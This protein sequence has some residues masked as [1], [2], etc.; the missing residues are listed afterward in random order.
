MQLA[1]VPALYLVQVRIDLEMIFA[2]CIRKSVLV[3]SRKG[4]AVAPLSHYRGRQKNY[5]LPA[6][7]PGGL[8]KGALISPTGQVLVLRPS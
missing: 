1:S 2:C 7:S 5:D 6:E 3:Q 4:C 8:T